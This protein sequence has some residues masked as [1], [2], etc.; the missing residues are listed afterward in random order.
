MRHSQALPREPRA[1]IGQVTSRLLPALGTTVMLD[2]AVTSSTVVVTLEGNVVTFAGVKCTKCLVQ[3]T[4]VDAVI[5]SVVLNGVV[6][7]VVGVLRSAAQWWIQEL[8]YR[9]NHDVYLLLWDNNFPT[10][11]CNL[12]LLHKLPICGLS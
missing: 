6:G 5:T 3:I 12:G 9:N 7:R 8:H 2:P 1:K 4:A 11:L 10:C